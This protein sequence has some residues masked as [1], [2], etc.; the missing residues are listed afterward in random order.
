MRGNGCLRNG[1]ILIFADN[2]SSDVFD[3]DWEMKSEKESDFMS[4]I[5]IGDKVRFN[6]K[7]EDCK[8]YGDREYTVRDVGIIGG[9]RVVWLHGLSGCF[10]EDGLNLES[11]LVEQKTSVAARIENGKI[12]EMNVPVARGGFHGLFIE[13][14]RSDGGR[15]S[16]SQAQYIQKLR[17]QGYQA[18]IC[19]GF[20]PAVSVIKAY[21]EGDE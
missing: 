11:K 13:M 17:M 21:L 7:Y 2:T 4:K 18:V 9:E 6:G 3:N 5:M 16:D 14:K 19:K 20:E 8:Q 12:V 1:F 10:A 15:L